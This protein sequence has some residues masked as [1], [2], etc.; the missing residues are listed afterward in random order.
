MVVLDVERV[1]EE[2]VV[3]AEALRRGPDEVGEPGRGLGFPPDRQVAVA[4]HVKQ[5]HR[6]DLQRSTRRASPSPRSAGCRR[7]GP[8]RSTRAASASSPSKNTRSIV[9]AFFRSFSTRASSSSI[10]AL[11]PPSLAPTKRNCR[12]SFVSKWPVIRMRSGSRAGNARDDVGHPHGAEGRLRFE[13]LLLRR[14][15]DRLQLCLDVVARL[16]DAGRARRPGAD[17]H[18]LPDVLERARRVERPCVAGRA[19]AAAP[20]APARRRRSAAREP[21]RRSSRAPPSR[22]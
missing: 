12:Y 13:G 11:D 19:A 3:V 10:A 17:G 4:D 18:E 7:C 16:L 8:C 2:R 22:T 20:A 14:E 21:A 5:D 1:G 6:L 15:A 9:Y